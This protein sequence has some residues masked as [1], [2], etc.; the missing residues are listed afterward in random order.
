MTGRQNPYF[1][2]AA[3][4]RLWAH[5]FGRGIV[6]PVD[7]L[8]S[9]N[10]PSHP[11]LLDELAAYFISG[12]YDVRNFLRTLA[13]TRAYQLSS[14]TSEGSDPPP[15]L[16]ARMAIKPLTAEQLYDCIE[17]AGCKR[18]GAIPAQQQFGAFNQSQQAFL[19]KFAAPAGSETEYHGGIP[20]ALTLM[21][22]GFLGDFVDLDKSDLLISLDAPFFQG[23]E[24]RVETLFLA[25]LSRP[26]SGEE[27]AKFVEYVQ[28]RSTD[29][30]RKKALADMLWAL[31]NSAE[32]VMNH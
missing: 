5:L 32:F 1:A 19:A 31:L 14:H 2:R 27:R 9:H 16:F 30:E 22:G 15:Q 6:D 13:S 23:D 10:P 12:N 26:P 20:Q 7:D 3:A 28:S 17:T 25:T 8:G 24:E 4:N 21:N 29:G 11:E 18:S